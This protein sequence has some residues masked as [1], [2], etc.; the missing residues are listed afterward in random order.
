VGNV[1]TRQWDNEQV[2]ADAG[3]QQTCVIVPR[4]GIIV[5]HR[6]VVHAGKMQNMG[7][8]IVAYVYRST[9]SWITDIASI[10]FHQVFSIEL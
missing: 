10:V 8:D 7:V 4:D 5:T 2:I 9:I 3:A 1:F 6:L